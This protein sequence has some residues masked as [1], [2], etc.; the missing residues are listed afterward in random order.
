MTKVYD[1][2]GLADAINNGDDTIEI[3]GDFAN[4]V[5]RIKVTVHHPV[6]HASF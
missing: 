6:L 4:K 1:A 5:I 3:E 2:E